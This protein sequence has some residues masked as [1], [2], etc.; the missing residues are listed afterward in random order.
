MLPTA[1]VSPEHLLRMIQERT[2]QLAIGPSTLRNQGA[3][4]VVSSARES[5]KHLDLRL[6]KVE[7]LGAFIVSLD[8]ETQNLQE[9]LPHGARPWGT[10]RKALNIFLR[11]ALYNVY[12]SREYA[13]QRLEPWLEVPLD[14][15]VAK[16]LSRQPGGGKLQRWKGIK[17]LD[18]AMSKTYQDFAVT[19]SERYG[20]S[21]VHLDL[22][23]WRRE[24]KAMP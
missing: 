19:V 5:L 18:P 4:R 9:A 21:R 8:N 2:A 3:S 17:D 24:V 10:A 6:F 15:Q 23:Y 11:D 14:G 16:A 7:T 20:V 12:L 1:P 22:M 13:L